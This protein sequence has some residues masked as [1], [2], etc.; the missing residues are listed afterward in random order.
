MLLRAVLIAAMAC[1]T[2]LAAA[3]P[4]APTGNAAKGASD[5]AICKTCHAVQPKINRIGPS[6]FGVVGRK[7]GSVAGARYSPAMKAKALVWTPS[8]LSSFLLSPRGVVPGTIM[9]F[10]GVAD[11]Q[12][13]A[14]I[15]AYLETLK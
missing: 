1:T 11:P 14:N 12:K 7:A 10:A 9:T 13:R 15:I 5:F 2:A 4:K 3:A 6:L 8:N